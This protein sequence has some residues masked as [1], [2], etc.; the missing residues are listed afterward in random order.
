MK[1][2][3]RIILFDA[4]PLMVKRTGVSYYIAQLVSGLAATHQKRRLWAITII[5]WVASHD[6]TAQQPQTYAIVPFTISLG[7]SSTCYDAS[8]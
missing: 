7:L 3:S 1:K 4:N 8:V 5:S 6:P 2:S